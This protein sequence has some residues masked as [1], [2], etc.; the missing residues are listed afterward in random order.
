M[1]IQIDQHLVDIQCDG[2]RSLHNNAPDPHIIVRFSEREDAQSWIDNTDTCP[3][4]NAP[5]ISAKIMSVG[6]G[7]RVSLGG[8]L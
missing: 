1:S 4:H 5:I 7:R 3:K 8:V 6:V 2:H